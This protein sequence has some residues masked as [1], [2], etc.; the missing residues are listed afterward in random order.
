MRF[1][2]YSYNKKAASLSILIRMTF[3][4][5]EAMSKRHYKP[6]MWLKRL[7]WTL[8]FI[9][10]GPAVVGAHAALLDGECSVARYVLLAASQLFFVCKLLDVS[11]LRCPNNRRSHAAYVLVIL[12]LHTGVFERLL[13][14]GEVVPPTFQLLT[15]SG[16]LAALLGRSTNSHGP[17]RRRRERRRV[18][19]AVR[20]IIAASVDAC[21]PPRLLLLA[22]A[23]ALHRSPPH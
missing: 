1:A 17:L 16:V 7:F 9:G 23:C 19:D 11:W 8:M 20:I 15:F 14:H 4:I 13:V 10:H 3:G 18:H 2:I 12:A 21:P 5:N 22:R 6:V